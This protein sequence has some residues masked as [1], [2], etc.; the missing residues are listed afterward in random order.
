[1]L[2]DSVKFLL[3]SL[4]MERFESLEKMLNALNIEQQRQITTLNAQQ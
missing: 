1:M 2:S 4:N 3:N